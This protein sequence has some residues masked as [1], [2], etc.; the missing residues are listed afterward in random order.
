MSTPTP[1]GYYPD[2]RGEMRYWDGTQWTQATR[3]A[4]PNHASR[5]TPAQKRRSGRTITIGAA[6]LVGAVTVVGFIGAAIGGSDSTG[7]VASAPSTSTSASTSTTAR[8]AA[9]PAAAKTTT[10][11]AKDN[12]PFG[13]TVE[14]DDGS[15]LTCA[16][17]VPF[18][19]DK[20]SAGGEGSKAFLKVKC[21]FMNG[22]DEKFEPALS[23]GSMSAGGEEGDSVYQEG[24]DAPDNPV[25]PG[26]SVTWW[27]GY[28]VN[29]TKDVQVT[30]R[31]GF[32]DYDPATFS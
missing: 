2:G 7:T 8:T 28:G 27:M 9:A 25:L 15:T 17:P 12:P 10:T 16:K 31:L 21:T 29:S 30:V 32:L 24:L 1:P 26:R 18:K 14:F 5:P 11:R 3:P 23:D 6:T 22:G 13:G 19:P 4:S 20:Y